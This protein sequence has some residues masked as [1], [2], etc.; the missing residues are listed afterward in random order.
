ME[1]KGVTCLH[2]ESWGID[3]GLPSNFRNI[4]LLQDDTPPLYPWNW[5]EFQ[6]RQPVLMLS[7]ES[8]PPLQ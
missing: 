7:S 3:P 6:S 4:T 5:F 1:N 2:A 8:N